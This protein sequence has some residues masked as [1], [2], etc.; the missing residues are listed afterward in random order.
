MDNSIKW[1]KEQKIERT[2]KALN[3][4][5]MNLNYGSKYK[6]NPSSCYWNRAS[7]SIYIFEI[8]Y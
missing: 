3:D 8:H 5:N 6:I 4:N 1:V 7:G 2:I